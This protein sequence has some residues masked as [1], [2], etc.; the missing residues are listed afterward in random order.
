MK[1]FTANNYLF[2]VI[3]FFSIFVISCSIDTYK[4]E[5]KNSENA[6]VNSDSS[7]KNNQVDNNNSTNANTGQTNNTNT[8]VNNN[9]LNNEQ[10]AIVNNDNNNNP[11]SNSTNSNSNNISNISINNSNNN[12][13]NTATNN[14]TNINSNSSNIISNN[15]NNSE[16][17]GNNSNNSIN[18]TNNNA[19]NNSNNITNNSAN[20]DCDNSGFQ[21]RKKY[22][23]YYIRQN[24]TG[25]WFFHGFQKTEYP[26]SKIELSL[27]EAYGAPDE[28]GTYEF[29]ERE[30]TYE[31]CGVCL[32]VG[33]NCV[34]D[35]QNNA[36]NCETWYMPK[37]V[38]EYTI[39]ELNTEIG[40]RFE[41]SFKNVELREV[42]ID[43]M[44]NSIRTTTI[45]D[46]GNWC[47]DSYSIEEDLANPDQPN[48][49][50]NLNNDNN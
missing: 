2:N 19:E 49:L 32:R 17:S 8:T 10:N 14:S 16:N 39:T 36:D 7:S 37:P 40:E 15:T 43:F 35:E 45:E 13:A 5:N 46:G 26:S 20:S 42:K 44:Q 27:W 1:P 18:N 24:R 9:N 4:D 50:N 31:D 34:Y 22:A 48:T 3:I 38:G 21:T 11:N 6:S 23:A 33:L 29:N 41:V 28:P 47:F 30:T 25:V 12:A